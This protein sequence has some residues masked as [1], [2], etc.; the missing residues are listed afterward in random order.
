MRWYFAIDEAGAAGATGEDAKTAVRSA[1]AVGGLEPHLLYYGSRNE[2][3]VWMERAGVRVIEPAPGFIDTA[4]AAGAAGSYRAH[5]LGHWPRVGV[6]L[7]ERE[8]EFVLYTDC[9]VMFLKRVNW[10]AFRPKIFAA[11]PEFKKDNWNYF[12]AGVMVLNVPAMRASYPGFEAHIT[13]RITDPNS[14]QYDDE[15]A[16]NEA[17]R[18]AWERLDPRLNWKPY[19]GY[20][21]TA[22]I[23]HSHG[24]KLAVIEAMVAGRWPDDNPT[25]V[26]MARMVDGHIDAYI[27]W[28]R[29]LGDQMQMSD[30]ARGLRMQNAASGLVRRKAAIGG[31]ALDM[32]FMDFCMFV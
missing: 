28:L 9:D 5:S 14:H 24:P 4:R 30:M 8:R 20:N 26:R 16:L 23:L 6:P 19:W 22:G 29:H 17:Y 25:A 1:L 21:S 18:G 13:G 31:K 2:F 3:T 15:V 11:A 12:N 10:E 27:T 7:V 32:G